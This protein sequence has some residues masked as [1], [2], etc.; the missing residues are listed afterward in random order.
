MTGSNTFEAWN[1]ALDAYERA[2]DE[3]ARALEGVGGGHARAA[4][5]SW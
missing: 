3:H 5:T 1:A 4:P 2:L